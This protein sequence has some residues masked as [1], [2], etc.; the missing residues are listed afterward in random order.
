M[1]YLVAGF[2]GHFI[3][4]TVKI[5]NFQIKYGFL[6]W[7]LLGLLESSDEFGD[8][9]FQTFKTFILLAIW[10]IREN[11]AKK[12]RKIGRKNNSKCQI[13]FL[14]MAKIEIME[15][16]NVENSRGRYEMLPG[17]ELNNL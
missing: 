17:N 10:L 9:F 13:N 15:N 1:K 2:I 6:F 14:K 3:W 11:S 7:V 4:K 16:D 8:L 5:K 12:S